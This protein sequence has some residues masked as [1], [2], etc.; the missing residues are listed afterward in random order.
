M[1]SLIGLLYLAWVA[2]QGP[3]VL[4]YALFCVVSLQLSFW[5]THKSWASLL[6]MVSLGLSLLLLRQYDYWL[7]LSCYMFSFSQHKAHHEILLLITGGLG[8]FAWALG[9]LSFAHFIGILILGAVCYILL[10]SNRGLD[11]LKEE[12]NALVTRQTSLMQEKSQARQLQG[13]LKEFYT[14]SER[15]R[16]SRELHD[17]VGHALATILIQ[18]QAIEGIAEKDPK[19]SRKMLTKL[20]EFTKDS[21]DRVRSVLKD[22]KPEELPE[23]DLRPALHD[24]AMSFSTYSDIRVNCRISKGEL[25]LPASV[26]RL[27]YRAAREFLNNSLKHSGADKIE[28][29]LLRTENHWKLSMQDDGVGTDQIKPNL[30]LRSLLEEAAME[31]VRVQWH[32]ELHGGF[33][34]ELEKDRQ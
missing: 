9:D 22:L 11:T 21:M 18:L 14:R 31:G 5:L 24:L 20:R 29:M 34:M 30:G 28:I 2:L 17:S 27:F 26:S 15:K 3:L 23:E 6:K 8:V 25:A 13:E 1:Y 4:L 7:L 10:K 19:S 32:S 16:L 33:F 12:K